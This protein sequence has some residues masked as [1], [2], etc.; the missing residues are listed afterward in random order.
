MNQ[1]AVFDAQLNGIIASSIT[2]YQKVEDHFIQ[3]N[4]K[5]K[6]FLISDMEP[7]SW[8]AN[9]SK[10]EGEGGLHDPDSIKQEKLSNSNAI[11]ETPLAVLQYSIALEYDEEK[12]FKFLFGPAKNADEITLIQSKYFEQPFAFEQQKKIYLD[13]INQAQGCIKIETPEQDFNELVNH[14]LPR[15]MFYHSNQLAEKC[16]MAFYCTRIQN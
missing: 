13:Y 2:P 15:Q 11:Y 12:S 3:Q 10:F 16:L 9:Q 8:C 5:D 1:S 6:T 14:W 7:T 4:F